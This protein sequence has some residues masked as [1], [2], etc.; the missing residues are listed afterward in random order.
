MFDMI[1][2]LGIESANSSIKVVYGPKV[3]DEYTYLNTHEEIE[4]SK[5]NEALNI[6]YDNVYEWQGK[7]YKV[8]LPGLGSGGLSEMR[9]ESEDYRMEIGFAIAKI[10]KTPGVKI[11]LC[12]GV[13]AVEYENDD[14]IKKIKKNLL[15]KYEVTYQDIERKFEIIEVYVLPQP[16]GTLLDYFYTKDLK[17]K[18]PEGDMLNDYMIHDIG[19]ITSDYCVVN[20]ET[21]VSKVKTIYEGMMKVTANIIESINRIYPGLNVYRNIESP[22]N[23]DRQLQNSYI[24]KIGSKRKDISQIVK[25]QHEKFCKSNYQKLINMDYD[26]AKYIH[27]MS[28]GGNIALRESQKKQYEKEAEIRFIK[29]PIKANARGFYI[30]VKQ[31]G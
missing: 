13:P 29:E 28:G 7:K 31:N 15:G 11:R 18:I 9:Y 30:F 3:N 14:T 21:G 8:G 4:H 16:V 2:D 26:L 22:F 10:I 17:E 24:V 27:L 6:N 5:I 1:L 25:D 12:T 23:L 20:L 19:S